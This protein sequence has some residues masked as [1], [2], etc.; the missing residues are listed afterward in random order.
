MKSLPLSHSSLQLSNDFKQHSRADRTRRRRRQWQEHL[1]GPLGGG[2]PVRLLSSRSSRRPLTCVALQWMD[3]GL[4]RRS[5]RPP[6]CRASRARCSEASASHL[7][8]VISLSYPNLTLLLQGQSV[9]V[10][11]QNFDVEQRRHW[12]EI[13]SEFPAVK[14]GGMV[15]GTS[16]EVRFL[17]HFHPSSD[18]D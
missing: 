4:P 9:I 16:L 1:V 12:L 18:A 17:A 11:R 5:R 14:V 6:C 15:M 2:R 7:T 8:S 3:Q 13:A 10:D